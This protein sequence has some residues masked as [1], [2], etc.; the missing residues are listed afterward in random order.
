MLLSEVDLNR[1]Y[2]IE[3][4][5]QHG[6]IVRDVL[7]E[8]N[9]SGDYFVSCFNEFTDLEIVLGVLRPTLNVLG[10]IDQWFDTTRCD[11]L[12]AIYVDEYEV[13]VVDY[14]YTLE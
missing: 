2:D 3:L 5:R 4:L 6:F 9:A 11:G 14:Y 10:M 1:C 12:M 7:I 13:L 8:R